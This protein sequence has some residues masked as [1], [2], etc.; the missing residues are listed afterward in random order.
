MKMFTFSYREKCDIV[1]GPDID[2]KS[3]LFSR[4]AAELGFPD[5]F[6]YNWN[7]FLDC[8]TTLDGR[9]VDLQIC[10]NGLPILDE[11]EFRVYLKFLRLA[12]GFL[13]RGPYSIE[14]NFLPADREYIERLT[15]LEMQ[16]PDISGPDPAG[17]DRG[18]GPDRGFR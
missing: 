3:M 15:T 1:L 2:G 18:P 17:P 4:Y 12:Q 16:E 8:I 6:G 9:E 13:R 10:H 5:Y 11:T 7:A 14:V